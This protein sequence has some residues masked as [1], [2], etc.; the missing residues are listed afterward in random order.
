MRRSALVALLA[1]LAM[2]T[3]CASETSTQTAQ[4]SEPQAASQTEVP[5]EEPTEEATTGAE[6]SMTEGA[7]DLA[8][9]LPDEVGGVA[10]QYQSASGEAVL[11]A[12]GVTPEVQEFL[13]RLDTDPSQLS[14]AFGFGTDAAAGSVV[15]IAAFRVEGA[16]EAQ[17]RDEFRNTFEAEGN[18]VTETTVAGKDGFAF[19]T[20]AEAS[21]GFFYVEGDTVFVVAGEP[22]DLAE[23][24]IS[25]LP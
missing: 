1:I 3:A 19:G 10:I 14:S 17:L 15:T 18:T 7:G 4:A 25:Q 5:T 23:E 21:G 16:D 20:D 24:A 12:E 2:L 13:D 9:V 11:G 8:G 22:P 6:P